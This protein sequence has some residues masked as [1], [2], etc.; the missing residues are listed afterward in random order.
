MLSAGDVSTGGSWS[1]PSTVAVTGSRGFVGSAVTAALRGAGHSA[2]AITAP[3]IDLPVGERAEAY[4]RSWVEREPEELAHLVAA[5][6]GADVVIHAAGLALPSSPAT[7]ALA[8][9]NAVLPSLVAH[10]AHLAGVRRFVHVSSAAVQGSRDPLDES[11]SHA[12][13]TP[14][15]RSKALGEKLLGTALPVPP[16]LV[17]FRPTSVQGAGRPMTA[18]L[19]RLV[20]RRLAPVF[21]DGE[22][23]LPLALVENV[24]AAA[25][26]LATAPSLPDVVLYPWEGMTLRELID[27]AG[28][29]RAIA[30]PT[31]C[32]KLAVGC[33]MTA[34]HGA[35]AAASVGRR[36]ELLVH[37]QRQDAR[38]LP[39]L[40]FRPPVGRD[41]Y[42]RL[43]HT[44]VG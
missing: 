9:A 10:A 7:P 4:A 8:G 5:M 21:G 3:R 2:H 17:L 25:V 20:S 43:C 14:Y 11:M 39:A 40:G 1:P 41:G 30:I 31:W 29:A 38:F 6:S 26:E 34:G 27:L 12:P 37:G 23:P 24:A 13:L 22:V 33:L 44:T 15:A 28:R 42:A 18:S 36:L 32:G 19:C 35:A 16:E